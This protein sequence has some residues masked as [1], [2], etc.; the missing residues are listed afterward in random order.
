MFDT[1]HRAFGVVQVES[2]VV[3]PGGL[4]LE[5]PPLSVTTTH[6]LLLWVGLKAQ[7]NLRCAAKYQT[8]ALAHS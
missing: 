6:G 7:W 3:E 5:H 8:R 1:V 2:G 4:L